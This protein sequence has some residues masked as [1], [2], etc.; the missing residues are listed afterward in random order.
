MTFERKTIPKQVIVEE[1]ETDKEFVR[2]IMGDLVEEF[3]MEH[4]FSQC[5]NFT[6]ADVCQKCKMK[7]KYTIAPPNDTK[8]EDNTDCALIA[9]HRLVDFVYLNMRKN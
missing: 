2:R 7:M 1:S 6:N 4:T 3:Q 8:H 9:L 5:P